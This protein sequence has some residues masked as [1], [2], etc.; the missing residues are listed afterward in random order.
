M[1]EVALLG[2]VLLQW[3]VRHFQFFFHF[4]NITYKN[5]ISLLKFLK[6]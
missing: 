6:L 5:Y 1:P 4:R 3:A 2:H